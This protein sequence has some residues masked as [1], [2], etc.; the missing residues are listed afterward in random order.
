MEKA[1]EP[2]KGS[3]EG[4]YIENFDDRRE[5]E[6]YPSAVTG[7]RRD[8]NTFYFEA[9]ETTLEF[10]VYSEKVFRFRYA[11]FEAFEDD[12][13]YA[14]ADEF[15][16]KEVA[17]G[18]KEENDYYLISTEQI[19]CLISKDDLRTKILDKDDN[20]IQEDEKGYHWVQERNYGGNV[21][22]STKKQNHSSSAF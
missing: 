12:F 1:V 10:K 8:G 17:I 3:F 6:F 7:F 18:F 16:P 9:T 19:K 20:V 22:I 2:K 14:V 11:N 5:G 15:Q 13:S 4:N 21:V